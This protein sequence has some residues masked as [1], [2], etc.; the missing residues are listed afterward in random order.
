MA[1]RHEILAQIFS[2]QEN[3]IPTPMFSEAPIKVEST[4]DHRSA[5]K[6]RQLSISKD[7]EAVDIRIPLERIASS[8][9]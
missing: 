4:W 6:Q 7:I 5:H 9:N 3:K 1:R 8:N 2:V